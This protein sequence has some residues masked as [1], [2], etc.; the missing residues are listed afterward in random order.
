MVNIVEFITHVESAEQNKCLM[1]RIAV[2][3]MEGPK[4]FRLDLSE[5]RKLTGVNRA[6]AFGY[7][8]WVVR[9]RSV[10]HSSLCKDD[11]NIEQFRTIA[12]ESGRLQEG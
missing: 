11:R 6:I 8:A 10:R 7:A 2:N 1:A 12:R 5:L 9:Q 3:A 4:E